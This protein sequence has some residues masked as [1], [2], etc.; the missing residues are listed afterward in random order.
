MSRAINA[1]GYADDATS[2]TDYVDDATASP[3]AGDGTCPS[4][5]T[6][7][8]SASRESAPAR[9]DHDPN[10]TRDSAGVSST[11]AAVSAAA[12]D[13]YAAAVSDGRCGDVHKYALPK[14]A[15][16][17]SISPGAVVGGMTHT[18]NKC[19]LM[20]GEASSAL[21][22]TQSGGSHPTTWIVDTGAGC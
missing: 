2:A 17:K 11:T 6:D 5:A 12:G 22:Y 13:V 18:V 9:S 10:G 16:P 3:P 7:A 4:N 21:H 14:H 1:A 8:P 15:S 19:L 20:P